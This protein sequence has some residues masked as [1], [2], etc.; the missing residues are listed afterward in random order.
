M[1]GF[2][3]C[4]LV[5]DQ[6]VDT[7]LSNLPVLLRGFA[8]FT[9]L[10]RV[11]ACL[12]ASPTMESEFLSL[13]PF[14]LLVVLWLSWLVRGK[15]RSLAMSFTPTVFMRSSD[16]TMQP[17]RGREAVRIQWARAGPC[18]VSPSTCPEDKGPL[19][20]ALHGLREFESC[21]GKIKLFPHHTI[22]VLGL[23]ASQPS[24][25]YLEEQDEPSTSV[26]W[27]VVKRLCLPTVQQAPSLSPS[28]VT[29][30]TST[31]WWVAVSY[32]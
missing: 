23:H 5:L 29:E 10:V 12:T 17:H 4:R 15:G 25:L 6:Q 14:L 20:S 9:A 24:W 19:P 30:T 11:T 26:W 31:N 21:L 2:C 1:R 28:G 16:F 7:S 3:S 32:V 27:F 18:T 22:S 8:P 13:F